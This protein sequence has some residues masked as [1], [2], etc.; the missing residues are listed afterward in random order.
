MNKLTPLGDRVIIKHIK[1]KASDETT[2]YGII[3][4]GGEKEGKPE[5]GE[6]IAV[7][8]G[9]MLDNGTRSQ[10][11]V[12]VGDK[13]LFEKGY[14]AN[15]KMKMDGEEYMVINISDIIGILQN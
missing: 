9:K 6:V 8:P 11:D 5:H 14:G 2:K 4:P 3:I 15:P 13:I 10:M 12:K 7:G 1:D